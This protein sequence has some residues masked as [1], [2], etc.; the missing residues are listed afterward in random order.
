MITTVTNYWTSISKYVSEHVPAPVV[1]A[2]NAVAEVTTLENA[3][4]MVGA[5]A[6]AQNV[7]NLCKEDPVA[8]ARKEQKAEHKR[9]AD[10]LTM[11]REEPDRIRSLSP[12]SCAKSAD[13]AKTA[14]HRLE[15]QA[16]SVEVVKIYHDL[17]AKTFGIC[18]KKCPKQQST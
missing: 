9:D 1:Q 4:K 14:I 16:Q 2:A 15:L 17:Y 11:M 5:A 13:K 7:Y 3:Q 8:K 12:R 18:T 10:I 6:L